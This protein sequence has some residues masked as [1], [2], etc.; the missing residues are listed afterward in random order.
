L[1][2]QAD[3]ALDV[4]ALEHGIHASKLRLACHRDASRH[5]HDL[6]AEHVASP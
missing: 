1:L 2:H 6:A 3:G 5:L 4:D